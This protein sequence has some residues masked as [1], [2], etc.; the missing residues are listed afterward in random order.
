MSIQKAAQIQ[1]F[2]VDLGDGLVLRNT[3]GEDAEECFAVVDSERKHLGKFLPWVEGTKT[4]EDI[5]AF[6]QSQAENLAAGR[7]QHVSIVLHGNLVGRI[8]FNTIDQTLK[9]A[10]IGYWLSKTV[11]GQGVMTRALLA[12]CQYGFHDLGL[13]RLSLFTHPENL[14]SQNVAK[15]CGFI[16][17]GI[18]RQAGILHGQRFNQI[19]FGRLRD[20]PVPNSFLRNPT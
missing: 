20:D 1:T 14:R 3:K 6:H 8:S 2:S 9:S 17:E 16:Q 13:E 11:E 15:R 18:F 10:I 19:W 12:L 5:R 7:C 4:V